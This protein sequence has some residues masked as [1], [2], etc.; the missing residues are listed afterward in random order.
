MPELQ[1]ETIARHLNERGVTN[2][3]I[4]N[5]TVFWEKTIE[6][7]SAKSF[8]EILVGCEILCAKRRAKWLILEISN[9]KFLLV[10]LRMTGNFRVTN[11]EDPEKHDRI[12]LDFENGKR[13]HYRDT[14]KFGR[15]K[16]GR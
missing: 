11:R 14:R 12:I 6:G 5:I 8:C 10:H 13:L 1:V 2:T 15:W 16:L 3:K 9:G 7:I 4:T